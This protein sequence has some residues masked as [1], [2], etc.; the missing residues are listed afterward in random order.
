MNDGVGNG[1]L[2]GPGVKVFL[3]LLAFAL[4]GAYTGMQIIL[5]FRSIFSGSLPLMAARL[6]WL[7]LGVWAAWFSFRKFRPL[8]DGAGPVASDLLFYLAWALFL[9]GFLG[10]RLAYRS[11]SSKLVAE[12]EEER[13]ACSS[14]VASV[15]AVSGP[16]DSHE[17]G[18]GY[19]VLKATFTARTR[20]V[21]QGG[22]WLPHAPGSDAVFSA[23]LPR[24][25]LETGKPKELTFYLLV[26]PEYEH[27]R[28]LAGDGPYFIP[29]ITAYVYDP[30][31]TEH[32]AT[33]A[34]D[35]SCRAPVIRNFT[36][37]PYKAAQMG[38][39]KWRYEGDYPFLP[40][41]PQKAAK[42][43]GAKPGAKDPLLEE[44]QRALK[45]ADELLERSKRD[46]GNYADTG[47]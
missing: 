47:K 4:L 12:M 15:L 38:R 31:R 13:Q 26:N 24:T 45:E 39:L 44:A 21:L 7:G 30:A 17:P 3:F 2:V 9:A 29:E 1:P 22:G 43:A 34:K 6:F 37:G 23:E 10:Y 20:L 8:R 16:T 35:L 42:R 32:W 46:S 19:I 11:P 25:E 27:S 40:P 14:H 28:E 18:S 41:D 33:W 5:A 36:T